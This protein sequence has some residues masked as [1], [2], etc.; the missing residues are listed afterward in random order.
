[1]NKE[2]RQAMIEI[3]GMLA[4][5]PTSMSPHSHTGQTPD[6]FYAGL[7]LNRAGHL[8]DFKG[9]SVGSHITISGFDYLEELKHPLRAWFGR[10]WFA[11]VVAVTTVLV[12]A[13]SAL[14]QVYIAFWR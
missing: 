4:E 7:V 1:M 2:L 12:S 14:A 9:G 8:A 11:F 3:L 5:N 13:A 6:R 10:N